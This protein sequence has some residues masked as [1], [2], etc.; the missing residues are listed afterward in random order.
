MSVMDKVKAAIFVFVAG[1]MGVGAAWNHMMGSGKVH[2][3]VNEGQQVRLLI[4]GQSLSPAS[5]SGEH[6][7]FDVKQGNHEVKIEDVESG[8]SRTMALEVDSGFD[9]YVLPVNE[10]QCFTRFDVSKT[11]Y[12]GRGGGLPTISGKYQAAGPFEMPSSSYFSVEELPQKL[13][14]NSSAYLL[15]ATPCPLHQLEDR[16]LLQLAGFGSP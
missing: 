7:R 10:E 2:I 6:L 9:D 14:K 8:K 16:Q 13:K 3:I 5:G 12:E 11:M 4:D 15:L 1:G